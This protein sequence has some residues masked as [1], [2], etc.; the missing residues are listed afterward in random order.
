MDQS[1]PGQRDVGRAELAELAILFGGVALLTALGTWMAGRV[2]VAPGWR[3]AAGACAA[4]FIVGSARLAYYRRGPTW[5]WLGALVALWALIL[6][7]NTLA[8]ARLW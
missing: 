1:N 5:R 4:V 7:T 2:G 6:L 3:L 8:D